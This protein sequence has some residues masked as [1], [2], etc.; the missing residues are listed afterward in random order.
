MI[1]SWV[2]LDWL[3][4]EIQRDILGVLVIKP[5]VPASLGFT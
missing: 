4:L 5:L 1:S 3:E 2:F